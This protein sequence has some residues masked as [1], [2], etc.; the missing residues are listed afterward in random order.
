M[1]I[2]KSVFV[3]VAIYSLSSF[4]LY[5]PHKQLESYQHCWFLF[6]NLTHIVPFFVFP[7]SPVYDPN[8]PTPRP[9]HWSPTHCIRTLVF[10]SLHLTNY[11]QI[12]LES[13]IAFLLCKRWFL[14][15]GLW[16]PRTWGCPWSA[17]LRL[18]LFICLFLLC[19][20]LLWYKRS[21]KQNC[22]CSCRN[23]SCGTTLCQESCSLLCTHSRGGKSQF[24]LRISLRTQWKSLILLYIKPLEFMSF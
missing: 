23:Q 22:W 11:Y 21:Y 6:Q 4:V 20:H 8:H 2:Y 9:L 18:F 5:F 1:S 13:F 16:N 14:K 3:L 12:F 10:S 17:R 7:L 24:S 15:Y 19:W